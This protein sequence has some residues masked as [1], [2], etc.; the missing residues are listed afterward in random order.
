MKELVM[1]EA[2]AQ[3]AIDEWL[4]AWGFEDPKALV[5]GGQKS[6]IPEEMSATLLAAVMLGRLEL[7]KDKIT[8][9]LTDPVLGKSGM[10]EQV[11]VPVLKVTNSMIRKY[12]IA[13]DISLD[14]AQKVLEMYTDG[15]IGK[16]QFADMNGRD[17][18]LLLAVA[19]HLAFT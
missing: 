3:A 9:K 12:S 18:S 4:D 19:A 1:C 15:A 17:T 6:S 8:Y 10:I 14:Q 16:A 5:S 2:T 13:G 7:Q 11:D